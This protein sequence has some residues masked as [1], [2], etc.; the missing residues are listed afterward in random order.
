MKAVEIV[1]SGKLGEPRIFNSVFSQQ[2]REGNIRLQRELGGGTL[3]DI[4][5][6]CI[7]AARYLFEAEPTEVFAAQTGKPVPLGEFTREQRP[8][9]ALEIE[10]PAV[11][12]PELI[13]AADPSGES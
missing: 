9:G 12:E 1:K 3:Y 13:H 4:G 11:E 2:V 5:I 7:N 8:G 6:Y 10:S